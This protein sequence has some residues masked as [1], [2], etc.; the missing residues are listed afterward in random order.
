RPQRPRSPPPPLP[1]SP[2]P[3]PHLP[4]PPDDHDGP[5]RDA[6]WVARPTLPPQAH[7][8]SVSI[9]ASTK[10]KPGEYPIF[11]CG[12]ANPSTNDYILVG[13]LAPPLRVKIVEKVAAAKS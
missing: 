12:L 13:Y 10:A 4:P 2:R 11:I 5:H 3:S 8:V 7:Q 6:L 1:T 9:S